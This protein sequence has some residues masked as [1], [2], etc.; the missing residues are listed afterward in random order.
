M[1]PAETVSAAMA[2]DGGAFGDLVT[3]YERRV[4]GYFMSR[5]CD[6]HA[7]A[8]L[9]Q[10][11]FV[12]ACLALRSLRD[13]ERFGPWLFAICR[14]ELRRY[15]SENAA[16]RR[17]FQPLDEDSPWRGEA[18]GQGDDERAMLAALA[19][20]EAGEREMIRLRYWAG[21]SYAELAAASGCGI[22]SAKGRLHRAKRKLALAMPGFADAALV[23]PRTF[24]SIKEN[25]MENVEMI[26]RAAGVFARLS[27]SAQAAFASAAASGT[28]FG[29]PLIA[30]LGAEEGGRE[31]LA[32]YGPQL[33]FRELVNILNLSDR[34]VEGR[35][36]RSLDSSDPDLAERIKRNM[37]VFEDLS[38]F[39][40]RAMRAVAAMADPGD[41]AAA[42]AGTW[43][44]VRERILGLLAPETS[45]ELRRIMAGKDP[46]GETMEEAQ[47]AV[48]TIVRELEQDG[49][50]AALRETADGKETVVITLR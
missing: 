14:N 24:E 49:K 44:A 2:G 26:R 45:G 38:L 50:L 15:F 31:F 35:L 9:S 48:V 8:E 1:E 5:T 16:S 33:G 40:E 32:D 34:Y 29:E 10:D 21:L 6:A 22:G 27:L 37:F 41:L 18:P 46:V 13:A 36:I 23:D 11:A 43:V 4:F 25:V 42:L 30:S 20:L 3:A 12:K 7:A 28:R 19:S 17:R 39:D 47:L